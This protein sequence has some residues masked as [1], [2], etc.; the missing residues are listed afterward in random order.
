MKYTYRIR[1]CNCWFPRLIAIAA[2]RVITSTK[3][4]I[5]ADG[6]SQSENFKW[7]TSCSTYQS[8]EMVEAFLRLSGKFTY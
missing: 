2:E 4:A 7:H 5:A 8:V 6:C 1:I 3:Y